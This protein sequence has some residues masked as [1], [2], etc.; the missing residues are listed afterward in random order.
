VL[1]RIAAVFLWLTVVSERRPVACGHRRTV[2]IAAQK[3]YR[4]PI[5]VTRESRWLLLAFQ[6]PSVPNR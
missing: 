4:R 1:E 2:Y 5:Q 6:G 3:G